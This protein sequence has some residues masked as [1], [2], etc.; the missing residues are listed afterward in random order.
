MNTYIQSKSIVQIFSIHNLLVF[1]KC[2]SDSL[3]YLHGGEVG[4]ADP[5]DD[6]GE[7][8]HGS[9][10]NRLQMQ[11]SSKVSSIFVREPYNWFLG[12][13]KQNLTLKIKYF[14]G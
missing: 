1:L 11:G 4:V 8:Q 5:H 6:D 14:K 9:L 10:H 13:V 12:M 7:R 3:I 2:N